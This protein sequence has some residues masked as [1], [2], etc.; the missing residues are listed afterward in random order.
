MKHL[1][2]AL[3]L[4]L[5]LALCVG[6]FSAC[7]GDGGSS[8]AAPGSSQTESKQDGS[9]SEAAGD[10]ASEPEGGDTASGDKID[11]TACGD[12]ETMKV[13]VANLSGYS[14]DGSM[15][16]KHL[17]E[18]YN[19]DIDLIV[20]PGWTDGPTKLNTLMASDDMPSLIWWGW[21]NDKEYQQWKD[22]GLLVEVSEYYNKYTNMRDYYNSMNPMTLFYDTEDDGKM[23]RMPASCAE[24]ACESLYIRQDWLDNLDMEVPTTI[25]ELNEVLRAFTEDDPDKNGK[26]DTYGLGGAGRDWRSFWPWL[27]GYDYTHYDRFVVDDQ[28]K[29]GYGPAMDNTKLWLG[30]VAEL[31]KKGYIKPNMTTATDR[32]QEMANGG[33]GVTY[34]WCTW[35]NK[36]DAVMKAFYDAHPNAKWVAIDMVKGANGDPQDDPSTSAAWSKFAITS[37]CSD[38]ER[39]F[40]I[41]DDMA[42][43]D[44]YI[45][46][47]YG[48]EG[49]HYT[50]DEDGEY[51]PIIH[52]DGEEN[53][54]QN[55]GLNFFY[56]I[57]YRTDDAQLSKTK[58]TLALFEK[59]IET[60]RARADQLVEWQNVTELTELQDFGTDI[61]DE[62]GRYM[63][64]VIAGEESID[65]WDKYIETLNGL[66]LESVVAQAQEV[67]DAQNA[68]VK[69]YMDNKVN[70]G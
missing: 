59:V 32:E 44:N 34:T 36:D 21:A 61:A 27:Q 53:T 38:P 1:K 11:P 28:G 64:G 25:E 63:W 10:D 17:E 37:A 18:K 39:L 5:A 56:P 48:F 49:E 46:R 26:D 29:V 16:Q 57:F 52:P 20:L 43:R 13:S 41:W 7:G 23:Y 6:L 69:A 47:I 40:A 31:Y 14:Q 12:M 54:T 58:P 68:K 2:K 22:A 30:E 33:F 42:E 70:Q 35:T 19:I 67:Y 24:P 62:A 4:V 9:S 50:F 60:S 55:I 15:M 8:S 45:E 3:C 51:S 66:S 65:D